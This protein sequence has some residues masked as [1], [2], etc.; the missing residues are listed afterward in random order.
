MLYALRL[1]LKRT[2]SI[3]KGIMLY[4]LRFRLIRR[5][6]AEISVYEKNGWFM[7]ADHILQPE[8]T[9]KLFPVFYLYTVCTTNG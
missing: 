8:L 1:R 9:E 6:F 5:I 4:A 2:L 7:G 3:F